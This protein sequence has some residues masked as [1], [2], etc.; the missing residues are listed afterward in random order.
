[1]SK[2]AQDDARRQ[3][4]PERQP[5]ETQKR[6]PQTPAPATDLDAPATPESTPPDYNTWHTGP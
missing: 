6:E 3:A 2:P 1:M 5:G 4:Q